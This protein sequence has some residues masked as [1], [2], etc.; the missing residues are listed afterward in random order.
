M[1]TPVSD[2]ITKLVYRGAE[3]VDM[4]KYRV[5]IPILNEAILLAESFGEKELLAKA[6]SNRGSCHTMLDNDEDGIRDMEKS[7][8]LAPNDPVTLYN[9]GELLGHRGDLYEAKEYLLKSAKSNALLIP[10][11]VYT[12]NFFHIPYSEKDLRD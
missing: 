12:L 4:G 2:K 8:E 7:L 1:V 3:L 5:A 6:L 9:M 11:I 10:R